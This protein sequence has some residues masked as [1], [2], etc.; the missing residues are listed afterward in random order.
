MTLPLL[1]IRAM[2]SNPLLKP[3]SCRRGPISCRTLKN[4]V[5][6][7]WGTAKSLL[8]QSPGFA[9]RN[10][11]G[12]KQDLQAR[13]V[14]LV[15]IRSSPM[16]TKIREL[17][18]TSQESQAAEN[19]MGPNGQPLYPGLNYNNMTAAMM[20]YGLGG[21]YA[22]TQQATLQGR[23]P[24]NP[25]SGYPGQIHPNMLSAPYQVTL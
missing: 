2:F 7:F 12:K 15:K 19:M 16:Q 11:N 3:R 24:Y 20:S 18:K 22:T 13:A 25:T 21:A 1:P 23:N 14:E 17:Y 9:G 8:C 4:N 6:D 5:A 10:K